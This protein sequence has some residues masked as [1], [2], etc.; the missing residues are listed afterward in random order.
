MEK[1]L[2][3]KGKGKE[4]FLLDPSLFKLH[5]YIFIFSHARSYTTLL[6]HILGSHRQISG[7]AETVRP[8][9]TAVDLYRLNAMAGEAGNY[10]NDCEYVLDKL[11]Y[12]SLTVSDKVLCLPRIIPIFV[13][14][15][16]EPTIA[17]LVRMRIH[18]HEQGLQVW[19]EGTDRPAAVRRAAA[20]YVKRLDTLK[21]LCTR[22][23]DLGRRGIFLPAESLVDDTAG[24]FRL[25]ERELDL[26]EPLREEY[27]IFEKTGEPNYGDTSATIR[28]GRIVRDRSG[29]EPDEIPIPTDLLAC[30]RDA[31][32]ACMACLSASPALSQIGS[33]GQLPSMVPPRVPA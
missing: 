11:L 15:E 14:R 27:A 21:A 17:S 33:A 12:D 26:S 29:Q 28:T 24:T 32:E 16:P 30:A 9:E 10:R 7:Y 8:Y 19:P 3:R 13:V 23:E 22:V 1:V 20:Y 2:V 5:R 25:L 18:E 31:Y 6:C 4:I